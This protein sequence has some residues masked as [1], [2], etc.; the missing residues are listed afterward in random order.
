VTE[1]NELSKIA[2]M[3]MI[4]ANGVMRKDGEIW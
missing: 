4:A 1:T 2:M 3:M